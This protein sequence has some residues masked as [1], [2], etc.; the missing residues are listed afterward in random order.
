MPGQAR[1]SVRVL[2]PVGALRILGWGGAS[3]AERMP[4]RVRVDRQSLNAQPENAVDHAVALVQAY[5]HINGYFTVT[6][7]PVLEALSEGGYKTATDID[8]LALRLPFAGGTRPIRDE[9]TDEGFEPDPVLGTQDRRPD[10]LIIEVKEGRAELNPGARSRDVLDAVLRRWG[11]C[12][13][14]HLPKTI[15]RLQ[16]KGTAEVPAG[17]R[18]RM[19]AFGSVI[20]PKKVRGVKAISL[21]HVVS[22]LRGYIEEH[23]DLL[24]HAQV[25]QPALGLLALLEQASQGD[26][27]EEDETG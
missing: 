10:L 6:E 1:T 18:I 3:A 24:R 27:G 7:Y 19:L 14:T 25:K 8:L 5:L 26:R 12:P 15:D 20:D 21:G 23:W 4:P 16:R 17:P 2:T 22:Y 11:F 13:E 9:Q